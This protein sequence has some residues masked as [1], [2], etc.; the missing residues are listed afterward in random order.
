MG[1]LVAKQ[2]EVGSLKESLQAAEATFVIDYKGCTCQQLTNVRRELRETGAT[3]SIVKNTL[4]KRAVEEASMHGLSDLFVGTSA[5]VWTKTP[6][7][8]AKV[9]SKYAKEMAEENKFILRGGLVDGSVVDGQG[10]EALSKL[11]SKEELYAQ[12]LGLLQAP[13][14]KLLRMMNAPASSLA[15]LLAT[16]RDEIEKRT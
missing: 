1:A 6:V 11:P 15:R 13:A 16:W 2:Q 9:L 7:E 10:V 14:S 12:L 5:V 3:L 8:S 4:M